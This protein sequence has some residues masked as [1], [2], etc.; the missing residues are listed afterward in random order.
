LSLPGTYRLSIRMRSR[1]EPI[2]FM[3]FVGST[4]EMI[5]SMNEKILDIHPYT[6]S[7]EVR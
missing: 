5:R 2:Y 1:G 7:F 3:K 6:V 4:D